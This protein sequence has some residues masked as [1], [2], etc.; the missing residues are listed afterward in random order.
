[1]LA[2]QT[3]IA[4]RIIAA[5]TPNANECS[6]FLAKCPNWL[7]MGRNYVV[8]NYVVLKVREPIPRGSG[9]SLGQTPELRTIAAIE[10]M[11]QAYG[12][13]G[14]WPIHCERR[15]FANPQGPGETEGYH[16]GQ[17]EFPRTRQGR[18]EI[19]CGALL[20]QNT[21]WT[22]VR[23][24][25]SG[26]RER[27][28]TTPERLLSTRVQTLR[29]IIRPAGYFNQKSGYLRAV[30]EWFVASDGKLCRGVRSR[31][32]LET[33]RPELLRVRGVGP[34]TADSILLYAYALPTF[35][36]DAYT[37]RVFERLAL[38]RPDWNYERIRGL[39]ES[40]LERQSV[41]AT[42]QWWQEAHALIVE[43][44]KRHHARGADPEKD[45]LLDIA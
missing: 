15:H 37:R 10:R 30:A 8:L 18:W 2:T 26:L 23:K 5:P 34:E 27:R 16:P 9:G 21:A 1:M 6:V 44:A 13:Q 36:V 20:T 14:W 12:P 41:D 7:A 32:L 3:P 17:F 38:V 35:V 4:V 43:H 29:S 31:K 11:A 25:L 42:V 28:I 19:C 40:A 33:W 45:F 24:A 22:N 39:F